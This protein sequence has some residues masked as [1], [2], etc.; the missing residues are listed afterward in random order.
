[1]PSNNMVQVIGTEVLSDKNGR[2][3]NRVTLRTMPT[4]EEW[5]N[6]TTGEVFQILAPAETTRVIGY[7]IPYLYESDDESA[8]SDYLWDARPG[9]VIKGK[10]VTRE[11]IPYMIDDN[12]R[13]S[14]TVFVQGNF[15]SDQEFETAVKMSFDRSGR[16]LSTHAV[17]VPTEPAEANTLGQLLDSTAGI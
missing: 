1:M 17:Q 7:R 5:T 15:D 8:I 4:T 2:E 14:A 13:N 11:V 16:T 3:Y 12:T 9:M 10:I 6:P